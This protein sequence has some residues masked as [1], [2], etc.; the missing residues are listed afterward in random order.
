VVALVSPPHRPIPKPP[1]LATL[2]AACLGGAFA[3]PVQAAEP[4]P[5]VVEVPSRPA[6]VRPPGAA[7][8]P[9]RRGQRLATK[10]LLRTRKPGRLQ[11]RLPDGRSFRLG[12]DSLVEI[13]PK[14]I[15][16]L[17]GQIIA[18]VNPGQKGGSGSPLRIRT[19]VATASIT[20]TTVFI[21]SSTEKVSFFSWEG[22][23]EVD[24]DQGKT[25]TLRSGDEMAKVGDTWQL[26]RPLPMAERSQRRRRSPLLNGFSAPMET[27]PILEKELGLRP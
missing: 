9:A 13:G 21:E 24:T 2:L 23:V 12:G 18:W 25:F 3:L 22:Q 10:T 8:Q 11:V 5:E 4:L 26:P 16:L 27:L 19:R 15:D 6:Y 20:G 14:G 1:L 7:E 17:R